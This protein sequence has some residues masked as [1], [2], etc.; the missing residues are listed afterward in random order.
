M[1]AQ[2]LVCLKR[3]PTHLAGAVRDDVMR[4]IS[5]AEIARKHGVSHEAA[6]KWRNKGL[7]QLLQCLEQT[8][9]PCRG[10]GKQEA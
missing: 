3:L 4:G 1:L 7:E 8:S 6:R 10:P 9:R 2:A 5:L